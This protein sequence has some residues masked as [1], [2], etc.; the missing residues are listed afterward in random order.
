MS[1]V[2]IRSTEGIT[3]FLRNQKTPI[4]EIFQASKQLIVHDEPIVLPNKERFIFELVCDRLSH[5]KSKEYRHS[6]EIW[7]L[8]ILLWT[9][10]DRETRVKYVTKIRFNDLVESMLQETDFDSDSEFLNVFVQSVDLVLD[11]KRLTF[12]SETNVELVSQL[13][14]LAAT[15]GQSSCI[16]LAYRLFKSANTSTLHYN[17]K[18]VAYFCSEC[19]PN[20]LV[21]IRAGKETALL[22]KM[23]REVLLR[24]EALNDLKENV[25]YF[26][27]SAATKQIDDVAVIDFFQRIIGKLAVKDIEELFGEVVSKFPGTKIELL[28]RVVGLNKVLST[29]FLSNLVDSSSLNL[30]VLQLA[31]SKNV[32][33]GLLYSDRIFELAKTQDDNKRFEL[34]SALLDVYVRSREVE[35]FFELWSANCI[36]NTTFVSDRFV[37]A[38]SEIIPGLSQKQIINL[39]KKYVESKNFVLLTSIAEGLLL[40]V[41]GIGQTSITRMLQQT[42][43]EMKPEFLK[44]LEKPQESHHYW[45]LATL[46]QMIYNTDVPT[47]K[48]YKIEDFFF[49]RLRSFESR[50]Q[51]ADETFVKQFMSF[52]RKSDIQFK[53]T[54]FTRWFVL[55][56][57]ILDQS[58]LRKL[59]EEYFGNETDEITVLA[60]GVLHEQS[61]LMKEVI[62][63]LISDLSSKKPTLSRYIQTIPAFCYTRSQREQMLNLL[64]GAEL[65]SKFVCIL[66]LLEQPTL[67]SKVETDISTLIKL[68]E[69]SSCPEALEVADKV[70]DT[71]LRQ[72]SKFIT[73]S[74]QTLRSG[75]AFKT[76][77]CLLRSERRLDKLNDE[78]YDSLLDKCVNDVSKDNKLLDVLIELKSW[79]VQQD[80]KIKKTISK[81]GNNC[82]PETA[83]KL[84][85]LICQLGK[86]YAPEYVL[87]LFSSLPHLELL[88]DSLKTYLKNFEAEELA[89]I[90]LWVL[91][92]DEKDETV[93]YLLCVLLQIQSSEN[94]Y[95]QK[96]TIA[97]L[98]TLLDL[99]LSVETAI[100]VGLV[101]KQ[102]ISGSSWMLTQY[103]VEQVVVFINKISQHLLETEQLTDAQTTLYLQNC[104]VLSNLV[105]F[106]RFRFSNRQ[107]LLIHSFVG[108]LE[109]LFKHNLG[110]AAATGFERLVSNL[111][112]ISASSVSNS[113]S[114]SSLTSTVSFMKHQ[115][116]KFVPLLILN[117][118]KFYLSYQM[119]PAIKD[120]LENSMFMVF[121]LLTLNELN[122]INM[123]L[124]SQSRIVYRS[125]YDDYKKFGKW[126]E[127]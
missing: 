42:A 95:A 78:L 112:E 39:V 73:E 59:V 121:D 92:T 18:N 27:N 81:I 52:Y 122:F 25:G 87:P 30:E 103:S 84:F 2:D 6:K 50:L 109:C 55:M 120:V 80:P 61:N 85:N 11:D 32:D 9:R 114:E 124:D 90:W 45:K 71:H 119:D 26:C 1:W 8:F 33:V 34:M 56:N 4:P 102:L 14:Q 108:L 37:T 47:K 100:Q 77:L 75:K 54:I 74:E 98:S 69:E 17:K 49:S 82:D 10:L 83:Q 115:L 15:A 51:S 58:Q 19:L 48:T 99:Q 97:S 118:V 91:D 116:R 23:L 43:D 113:E 13:L 89:S 70:F 5:T 93:S 31:I 126:R 3:R 86:T 12:S 127:E 96:L 104:Q 57:V 20:V 60:N 63:Y 107:H 38:V 76:A 66:A 29:S 79:K 21:L 67:K 44:V 110:T 111:C 125:L 117:Y 105:L 35:T 101:L 24:K 28:K 62:D 46:M 22:E 7:D 53:R 65:E 41:T 72:S 68:V 40:G 123:S 16:Q 94:Q 88:M 64:V 36:E 106:Q